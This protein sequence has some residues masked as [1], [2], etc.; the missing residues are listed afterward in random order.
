MTS[1]PRSCKNMTKPEVAEL[2]DELQRGTILTPKKK[3]EKSAPS[4]SRKSKKSAPSISCHSE[5]GV[6]SETPACSE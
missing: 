5:S 3:S 1:G 2:R 4:S 6:D